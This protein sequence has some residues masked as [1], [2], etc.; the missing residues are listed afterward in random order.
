MGFQ[1]DAGFI[2]G[3]LGVVFSLASFAV[4]RMTSLRLLAMVSNVCFIGYGYSIA[5]WP[6]VVLNIVLLPINARRV[7]EIRQLSRQIAQTTEHAAPS[8]W[9]L[10]HMN[11]RTARAGD[12]LFRKGDR[13]DRL[14]LLQEGQLRLVEI[15]HTVG[16]GELLGEI[17]LF[18]HS[19]A[20]TLTAVCVTDIVYYEMT[21]EML[22]QLYYQN[23][24]LGFEIIRLVV[25]RLTR[26][27][28]RERLNDHGVKGEQ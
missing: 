19:R 14:I 21:D 12:T 13:A 25:A 3:C 1:L 11:R 5:A 9:L 24:R 27:I 18:A 26:D 20:R 23:P 6:G 15:G 2:L 7:W 28:E 22:F 16:A 4:K 10:P 8:E 17:G